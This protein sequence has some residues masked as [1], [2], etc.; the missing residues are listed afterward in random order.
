MADGPP[1][2]CPIRIPVERPALDARLLKRVLGEKPPV[3]DAR[4]GAAAGGL[5]VDG[6]ALAK[7]VLEEL[8][9]PDA[10]VV[11]TGPGA[12]LVVRLDATRVAVVD[13]GVVFG[14][15]VDGGNGLRHRHRAHR[16]RHRE[17]LGRPRA[18]RRSGRAAR[19]ARAGSEA[20]VATATRALLMV[21]R[22]VSERTGVDPSGASFVPAS[23][24]ASPG[25]LTV[26]ARARHE[27]ER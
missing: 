2:T 16:R 10:R 15:D 3:L 9:R 5:S 26:V 4:P 17:V 1:R 25:R 19:R 21:A 20:L 11:W 22:R 18:G 7:L 24:L 14:F 6:D 27:W 12:D 23:L 8:T 13:G